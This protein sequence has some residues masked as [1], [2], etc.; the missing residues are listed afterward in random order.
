MNSPRRGE[1]TTRANKDGNNLFA[2]YVFASKTPMT[3]QNQPDIISAN[4]AAN[5]LVAPLPMSEPMNYWP[6]FARLLRVSEKRD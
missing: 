5:R 4:N 1:L 3:P 2:A 6:G